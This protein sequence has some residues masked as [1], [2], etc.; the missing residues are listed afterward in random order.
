MPASSIYWHFKDKDDL[1]AVV[2]ERSFETWLAAVV[3][4]EKETGTS[5]ERVTAMAANVARSLV[6]APDFLRLG[7]MLALDLTKAAP[8]VI[9]RARATP[10]P[11]SAGRW[12]GRGSEWCRS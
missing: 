2:V 7:L 6:D 4:P 3:L 9:R 10:W 12:R 11:G 1:I 5:P 8:L